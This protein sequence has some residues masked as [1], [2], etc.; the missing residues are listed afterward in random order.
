MNKL[1]LCLFNSVYISYINVAAM[2]LVNPD[3]F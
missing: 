2:A 3:K 1:N